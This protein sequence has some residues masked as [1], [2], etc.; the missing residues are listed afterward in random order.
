MTR[1]FVL[2]PGSGPSDGPGRDRSG[3]YIGIGVLKMPRR[4]IFNGGSGVAVSLQQRVF[5]ATPF[6]GASLL[7]KYVESR[8]IVVSSPRCDL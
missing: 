8:R 4:E 6:P 2:P 3:F 7:Q 5:G 1:G